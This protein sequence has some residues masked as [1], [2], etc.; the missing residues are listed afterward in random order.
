MHIGFF[1]EQECSSILAQERQLRY[2]LAMH[3][4]KCIH[5]GLAVVGPIAHALTHLHPVLHA[6]LGHQVLQA[7]LNLA[8]LVVRAVLLP[9]VCLGQAVVQLLQELAAAEALMGPLCGVTLP[10]ATQPT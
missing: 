7:G 3:F 9:A 6:V 4:F 10:A 1:S 2:S 8:N 5:G